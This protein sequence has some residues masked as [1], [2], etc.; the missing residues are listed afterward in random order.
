[1]L[2]RGRRRGRRADRP[3][4]RERARAT[5]PKPTPPRV[6]QPPPAPP[7][8]AFVDAGQAG[9][10]AVGFAYEDGKAIVTLTDGNGDG[11]TDT[12]VA[13]DG[14]PARTA[15]A[16]ASRAPCPGRTSRVDVGGTQLRSR[17]AAAPAARPP[18]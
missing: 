5:T 18:R 11:V 10:I 9:T 12:P 7:R 2:L 8:G 6:A 3:A 13:I 1:M 16:A 17:A 15:A 14:R 4:A